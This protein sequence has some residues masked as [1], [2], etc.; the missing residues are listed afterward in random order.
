MPV[1]DKFT[2]IVALCVPWPYEDVHYYSS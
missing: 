2:D 1:G